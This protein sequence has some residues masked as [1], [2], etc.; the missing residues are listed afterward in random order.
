MFG[1]V[2]IFKIYATKECHKSSYSFHTSLVY[3]NTL[4]SIGKLFSPMT[5][6]LSELI[7]TLS[8]IQQFIHLRHEC[9]YAY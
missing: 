5:K 9:E 2:T 6:T 1:D 3:H 8:L 7:Y 4:I